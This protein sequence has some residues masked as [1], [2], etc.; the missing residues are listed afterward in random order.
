MPILRNKYYHNKKS[1]TRIAM[2][3]QGLATFIIHHRR[4][5]GGPIAY[6]VKQLPLLTTAS[7]GPEELLELVKG[8]HNTESKSL[9]EK[10]AAKMQTN[11]YTEFGVI[12]NKTLITECSITPTT[13]PVVSASAPSVVSASAPVVSASA[14]VVSVSA[15]TAPVGSSDKDAFIQALLVENESLQRQIDALKGKEYE[16]SLVL[17]RTESELAE[18]RG[19]NIVLKTHIDVL[20]GVE[21]ELTKDL[22]TKESELEN[23]TTLYEDSLRGMSELELTLGLFHSKMTAERLG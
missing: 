4:S 5:V 2:Q 20:S 7:A 10:H 6:T 13:I 8:R 23:L 14:P 16:L 17:Q 21:R 22:N 11:N 9:A 12:E 19:G 15:P 18:A 3:G 1:Q